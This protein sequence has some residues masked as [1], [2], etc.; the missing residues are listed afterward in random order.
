M[1]P[2]H[3]GGRGFESRP[4]RLHKILTISN[5]RA[6]PRLFCVLG[7]Y[8]PPNLLAIT[9]D[10]KQLTAAFFAQ[11]FDGLFDKEMQDK[12]RNIIVNPALRLSTAAGGKAT[13]I[14]RVLVGRQVVKTLNADIKINPKHWDT[15]NRQVGKG[16][17]NHQ[18][19]N[20]KLAKE[21]YRITADFTRQESLG[22]ELT[23]DRA[24]KI[25]EGKAPGRDFYKFCLEWI[26]Q[27]YS[28][29][30]TLRTYRSEITKL[31]KF[32]K[33]LAFGDIDYKFLTNYK[34]YMEKV[35]KNS[36]NTVWKSFKFMNTMIRDAIKMKGIIDHNPF[37]NF[38]HGNYKNP[39]KLGIELERED[40]SPEGR[41]VVVQFLL[42]CYSGLRF[43]DAMAFELAV[44][45]INNDRIFMKTQKAGVVLNMKL[46]GRLS[47]IISL[48]QD[49]PLSVTSNQ[50]FNR[51]LKIV[52]E[53]AGHHTY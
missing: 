13:V 14:I 40:L 29:P 22:V 35:L 1:P 6:N 20:L 30:E 48:L 5:S 37:D 53:M 16:D 11:M 17:P 49:Q 50:D 28:K 18:V 15:E 47:R 43:E 38:N 10:F 51:W 4:V 2:C 34:G 27:K 36:H 25:A 26:P 33:E 46:Y 31:E 32:K 41:R 52:A 42:M 19:Y 8:V 39:E 44:H 7:I 21:I 3:G 45:V 24:Q 9:G 12:M 23:K